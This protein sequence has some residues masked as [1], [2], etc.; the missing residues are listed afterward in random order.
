MKGTPRYMADLWA[1]DSLGD[2]WTYYWRIADQYSR[3]DYLFASPAIFR[4]VVL[5][6]SKVYR[7][8]ERDWSV[9]SDHRPVYTSII[10]VNK[11]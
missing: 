9:A 7:S 10:P 5:N 4:E 8:Q 6:K 2:R 11:K 3:I 1:K